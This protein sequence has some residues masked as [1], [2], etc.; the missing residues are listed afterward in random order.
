MGEYNTQKS[1]FSIWVIPV[2]WAGVVL[3]FSV[4]PYKGPIQLTVGYFD[5]MAHFFEYTVLAALLMRGVSYY[6]I[7]FQAKSAL[8]TLI[9]GGGYGILME[10]VQRLVPGRDASMGD[11]GANVAGTV[12]GIILGRMVKW[13]K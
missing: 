1:F 12:F 13:Q 9:L 10:L 3:F 11:V 4:L 8:F 2:V 5:K 6:S 7:S